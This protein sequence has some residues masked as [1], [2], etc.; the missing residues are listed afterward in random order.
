[1]ARKKSSKNQE[2]ELFDGDGPAVDEGK[3]KA[4]EATLTDINKRYGDGAI[5]RLGDAQ[6]MT[7]ATIPTG[8]LT[9]D[10]ALGV[11]GV[12]RGRI[13]EI[14]EIGRAHV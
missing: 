6:N 3:A 5:L 14:Y 8:S 12:P 2:P 11:G 7:V 4:L 1:M 9:V 10:I 13:T